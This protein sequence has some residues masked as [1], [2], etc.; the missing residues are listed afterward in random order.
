M[1]QLVLA[2]THVDP[3]LLLFFEV[4]DVD[5][6]GGHAVARRW[7]AS[8]ATATALVPTVFFH[9]V[10]EFPRQCTQA[11]SLDERSL[12]PFGLLKQ[13]GGVFHE[14]RAIRVASILTLSGVVPAGLRF[15]VSPSVTLVHRGDFFDMD[16]VVPW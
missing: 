5:V 15:D 8:E 1:V 6:D 4:V 11:L 9:L 3:G 13:D 2:E 10:V 14:R 12:S 7:I 16:A